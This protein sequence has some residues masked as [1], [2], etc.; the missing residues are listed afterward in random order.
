[1][2]TMPY[3]RP[4]FSFLLIVVIAT[5]AVASSS[6]S[7]APSTQKAIGIWQGNLVVPGGSLRIIFKINKQTDGNLTATIDSPDQGATDIPVASVTVRGDSLYL[8]VAV[9]AASFQG[10]IKNDSTMVGAWHQSGVTLPLELARTEKAPHIR[11]PQEPKPP[12]P[13]LEEE[14]SFKNTKDKIDL[15]GTLTLPKGQGR[16]PA[17]I[18]IS[19]SGP[20]DRDETVFGH[21]PFLIIADYL[22]RQGI[23]VLRYDDRGVGSSTGDFSSATT[24]DFVEDALA[25]IGYLKTRSEID[26]KRIGLIGHSEGGLVAPLAAIR[27]DNV[28]FIV[29]LAPPAMTGKEL[30]HI[31]A[32]LI[33]RANG[34]SEEMIQKNLDLQDRIL[35]VASEIKDIEKARTR[36]KEMLEQAIAQMTEEERSAIG[37]NAQL[38]DK[39]VDEVLSPWFRYFL[40]YDPRP[41]LSKVRCPVLALYGEKDLQVPPL[42]NAPKL[43]K[44]LEEG[45]NK[46]YTVKV[47]PNLNHLF[48]TAET[49]S[50]SEYGSI[51]ETFSPSALETIAEWIKQHLK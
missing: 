42:D 43:E 22:T 50:P 28:A 29:L 38:I 12:Y 41:A 20:Q 25:A 17:V 11:R 49:G 48:Q 33:A 32:Q 9:I 34:A 44:A 3:K 21:K 31:Q 7:S 35:K 27:S 2:A 45:G 4:F 30:L 1:M 51:E 36:I 10:E 26:P 47:F 39:Q 5:C 16:F 14:V 19:G 6:Q 8:D 13:Y 15:A 24:Q 18:L 46:D 40:T 37:L 23:A